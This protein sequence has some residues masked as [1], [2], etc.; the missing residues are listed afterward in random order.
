M[1][2]V[3]ISGAGIAGPALAFWL[4]R[5]G[6]SPTLV[7]RAPRPRRGGYIIDCWGVGYDIVE[8]MGLL[9]AVLAAGYQLRE[10]RVVN[11]RGR[12]VS[13][14][15]AA[16]FRAATVGRYTS[17][18]RGELARILYE[19][20]DGRAEVIFG[21]SISALEPADDGVCVHFE[22]ER[23]RR[24]DLVVGADGLHSAVRR[25]AWGAEQ[26]YE[27]FLGYNVAAFSLL[28][29]RPREEGVYV[30]YARPG[31]QIARFAL[32][33]DRTMFLCVVADGSGEAIDAH[34]PRAIEDYLS[35]HF[36]GAGWECDAILRQFATSDDP[37]LD[38]VSQ[39]RMPQWSKGCIALLGDAAYA[40]SL[41][42]GQG[43]ALAIIGAYVLAGELARDDGVKRA[44]AR[45]E[46]ELH[47]FM[48]K[49]QMA[50]QGVAG[51]FAPKT[52]LGVILRNQMLRA[53][54]LPGVAQLVLRSN[55]LDRIQLR[56]YDRP[57]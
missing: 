41:L 55:L 54:A 31:R 3:L 40:P 39:I 43:A 24:F 11:S 6:L 1:T 37:Y 38:R 23:S 53:F 48:L 21:D 16:V 15:D 14:M 45:Y 36:A 7:E 57:G 17:I 2:S 5:H 46:S 20:L 42:A 56:D 32:R 47:S 52:R 10:V 29:Y 30:A 33:G 22:G 28:G 49:K 50:A 18:P 12:R 34:D 44:L 9:P 8:K 51:S 4:L 19:S 25:L 35:R 13:S 27:K 26:R